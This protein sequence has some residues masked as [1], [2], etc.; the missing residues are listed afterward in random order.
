MHNITVAKVSHK[1]EIQSLITNCLILLGTSSAYRERHL[2]FTF[3]LLKY[4]SGYVQLLKY[5]FVR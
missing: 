4:S 2:F 5:L 1:K 3:H